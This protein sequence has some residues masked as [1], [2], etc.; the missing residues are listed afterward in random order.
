[1]TIEFSNLV[2][3]VALVCLILN[4]VMALVI[5]CF[6]FLNYK[7]YTEYFKDKSASARGKQ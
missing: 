7:L 3:I 5:L 2:V 6:T 4:I 1:M